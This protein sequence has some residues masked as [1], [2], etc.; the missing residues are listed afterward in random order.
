[1]PACHVCCCSDTHLVMLGLGR[2]GEERAVYTFEVAI[3]FF[4]RWMVEGV[5]LF[6]NDEMDLFVSEQ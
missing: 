6:E 5:R 2:A 3:T 4:E 1:M